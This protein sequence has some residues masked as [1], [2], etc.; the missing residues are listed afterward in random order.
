MKLRGYILEG[1]DCAG[2]TKLAD[3][4]WRAITERLD[5][6]PNPCRVK[7]VKDTID[8]SIPE[9]VRTFAQHPL[10]IDRFFDSQQVYRQH[11]DN[12]FY[13]TH[14]QW[15]FLHELQRRLGYQTIFVHTVES[16]IIQRILADQAEIVT[17]S[18][19]TEIQH[20]YTTLYK[21]ADYVWLADGNMD[22]KALR[23]YATDLVD[24]LQVGGN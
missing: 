4:V 11:Y 1:T 12:I 7:M 2:K 22:E 5:D 16:V 13:Y 17:A 10:I 3:A 19:A 9:I 24:K 21:H 18:E 15:M 20:S 14:D 6:F 23:L 8:W